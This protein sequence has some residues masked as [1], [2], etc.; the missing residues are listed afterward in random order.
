[1]KTSKAS[2]LIF[3]FMLGCL[4]LRSHAQGHDEAAR[5]LATKV[6]QAMGGR[7]NWEKTTELAFDFVVESEGKEVTRRSHVWNRAT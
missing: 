6:M 1:M 2:W 4:S 7:E 3:V 5:A